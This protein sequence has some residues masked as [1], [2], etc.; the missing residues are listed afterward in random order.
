MREER[1]G[2]IVRWGRRE[3][4]REREREGREKGRGEGGGRRKK[5]RMGWG[6]E[7]CRG[8]DARMAE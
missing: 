7:K 5:D 3:R 2:R 4:E 1:E 6:V 8:L